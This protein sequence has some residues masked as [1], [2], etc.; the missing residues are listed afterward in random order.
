MAVLVLPQE[1]G[2]E[3]A[4][5]DED[6]LVGVHLLTILAGQGHISEV[7]VLLQFLKRRFDVVMEIIPLQAQLLIISTLHLQK[8]QTGSTGVGDIPTLQN[9]FQQRMHWEDIRIYIK[10]IFEFD[11]V[12][13]F[14]ADNKFI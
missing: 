8:F 4:G 6:Q 10:K 3:G 14:S 7:F 12:F 13:V 2:E 11:R 5:G 9:F 1:V